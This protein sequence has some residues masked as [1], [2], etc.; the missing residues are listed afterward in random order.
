LTGAVNTVAAQAAC[1]PDAPVIL[2]GDSLGGYTSL[3]AAA[4]IPKGQL[5]GLVLGGCSSNLTGSALLPYYGQIALFKVLMTLRGEERLIQSLKPRLIR[6]VGMS[7]ADVMAMLD[8]GISLSVFAPA[9]YALRHVDFRSK[10]AEVEV[11]VL[12]LNGTKDR[13]HM[14]QEGSFLA[15]AR[16]A[17]AEH[18]P[19]CEHGVTIRRSAECAAFINAF[20]AEAFA[21]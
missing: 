11:P 7:E 9:V 10:L 4:V 21:R 5:K 8:A 18:L 20:A 13:G 1:V 15:V 16:D 17:R 6:E 19:D 3:A 2:A 14:R 12:I